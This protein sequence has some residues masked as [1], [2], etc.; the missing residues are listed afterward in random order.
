MQ[1]LDYISFKTDTQTYQTKHLVYAFTENLI[2]RKQVIGE[3]LIFGTF[4]M[5]I[6]AL[7]GNS[8]C[9]KKEQYGRKNFDL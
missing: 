1:N 9:L 2:L 7:R 5:L 8:S 3:K 4:S 6:L